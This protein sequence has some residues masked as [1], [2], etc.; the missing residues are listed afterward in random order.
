[1]NKYKDSSDLEVLLEISKYDSRA[2]EELYDRYSAF[3]YTII[4]KIVSSKE[5]ADEILVDVFTIIWRKIDRF[6]FKSGNAY[7]WLVNIARN[8]AVD[9][10]RRSKGLEDSKYTDDYEN[11]YILPELSSIID[12]LDIT[13]A[14][15]IKSSIDEALDLLTDAQKYVIHLAYYDGL[16]LSEIADELN[17]PVETVRSKVMTALYKLKDNLLLG[18]AE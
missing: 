11:Y 3:L 6:N 8:K 14:K 18:A 4:Q 7:A 10:L 5:R 2:L 1:M 16:T 12:P 9:Y 13:T 15:N 17:I